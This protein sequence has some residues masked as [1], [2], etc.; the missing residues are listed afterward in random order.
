MAGTVIIATL[1][2][3]KGGTSPFPVSIPDDRRDAHVIVN[4]TDDRDNIEEW[5]RIAKMT[6]YV[7]A[8]DKTYRLGTDVTIAG[9]S[10]TDEGVSGD[11]QLRSEKGQAEG[12]CPLNVDGW[13][14]PIY[15]RK[16][17]TQDSYVVDDAQGRYALTAA[18][19]DICH[20]LDDSTV[21]VKLNNNP[22]TTTDADWAEITSA[23]EVT[24]VNGMVGEVS[25]TINELLQWSNNSAEFDTAVG[26]TSK[27]LQNTSQINNNTASIEILYTLLQ[28]LSTEANTE[29]ETYDSNKQ[30]DVGDQVI[31]DPG[32]GRY[33]YYR[34]HT[35]P[36]GVNVPPTNESYWERIGDFYTTQEID[37]MMAEKADLVDGRVPLSQLPTNELQ[38]FYV[39]ADLAERND[40]TVDVDSRAIVLN[41]TGDT[42]LPNGGLTEYLYKP[43]DP[44]AD[45]EGWVWCSEDT[46]QAFDFNRPIKRT[47]DKGKV[48]GGDTI[49]EGLENMFFAHTE[50]EIRTNDLDLAMVGSTSAA[51]I[52]GE[53]SKQEADTIDQITYLRVD[54]GQVFTKV[55][56]VD[57]SAET[58]TLNYTCP[59][60]DIG[61]GTNET[62]RVD[63]D[64][65]KD[66]QSYTIE[67]DELPFEGVYPTMVQNTADGVTDL[68]TLDKILTKEEN[69]YGGTTGTERVYFAIPDIYSALVDIQDQHSDSQF[70]SQFSSTPTIVSVSSTGLTNNW[71]TDYK[72]Y[73]S[74]YDVITNDERYGWLFNY[75]DES[76]AE[77][78]DSLNQEKL[79][80]IEWGAE[81]NQSDFQVKT[82]YEN[83]N[84]TNAFRDNDKSKLDGIEAGAQVNQDDAT[85]KTQYENNNDTNAYTDADKSKL[86]GIDTNAIGDMKQVD[87]HTYTDPT[88]RI[89]DRSLD[90]AA[91]AYN[92]TGAT[93][94]AGRYLVVT[95]VNTV[96]NLAYIRLADN[97]NN[98]RVDAW[99]EETINDGEVGKIIVLGYNNNID[100]SG[101]QIDDPA[102]L[103]QNGTVTFTKPTTGS[104]IQVGVVYSVGNPGLIAGLRHNDNLL[105]R[106]F[107]EDWRPST[108][109]RK[110][111]LA[112]VEDGSQPQLG[113]FTVRAT[114]DHISAQTFVWPNAN[115]EQVH[116][117]MKTE[118][119]DPNGVKDDAFL[120]DNFID[121]A[122]YVRMTQAERDKL[123]QTEEGTFKGYFETPN[124]LNAAY[125]TGEEGWSAVVL[126]ENDGT[127]PN[128]NLWLWQTS[129]W[130]D[131]GVAAVGGNM[132]TAVYDTQ[133]VNDDCFDMDNFREG[134]DNT[135]LFFTQTERDKLSGLEEGTNYYNKTEVDNAL[136]QKADISYVDQQDALKMD[137]SVYDTGSRQIVDNSENVVLEVINTTGA[138]LT[139]G[140]WV[141][142]IGYDA[143]S[144]KTKIGQAD[145]SLLTKADGVLMQDLNNNEEGLMRRAG[146][147]GDEN[148]NGLTVGD[149]LYLGTSGSWTA[150]KPTTGL[151]QIVGY[152]IRVDTTVGRI[153][154]QLEDQEIDTTESLIKQD[155]NVTGGTTNKLS[156]GTNLI[157]ELSDVATYTLPEISTLSSTEYG[158]DLKNISGGNTTLLTSGA[159][160]ME[161]ETEVLLL[162]GEN[163]TF[164]MK[165]TEYKII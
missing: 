163:L 34:C 56:P 89:V 59:P 125:P 122:N 82:Q 131:S 60:T 50:P 146:V 100:T 87:Y 19:G 79:D 66:G 8:D 133:N 83:N 3:G 11:Y 76:Q 58:Q 137:I 49:T 130:V 42:R 91:Q 118:T 2:R 77:E 51:T 57:P 72:L 43:S 114:Q 160:T 162:D 23:S 147:Q 35:K 124:D 26:K 86:D 102:Y 53:V 69:I 41:A 52:T 14:D 138:A 153:M 64:Y 65:T 15:V 108:F 62:Y 10:W 158:I 47:P 101:Q 17:H 36:V 54:D 136:N 113:K 94:P 28:D 13:I 24:S 45:S 9:Q 135:H 93:I 106:A 7:T 33:N 37:D 144:G 116:G 134:S 121:T 161:G 70:G 61:P 99:T 120:M 164:Y 103:G 92:S 143:T 98:D 38:Q 6:C 123:A 68:W 128:G 105:G 29:I 151:I 88:H 73:K 71:T 81:V 155:F 145:Q 115:W 110:N 117:D 67:G 90:M 31:Y 18:T 165:S 126:F 152:V 157:V 112:T 159:D 27:V 20:Q 80:S 21:W 142:V 46:D 32:V 148:T 63:V 129:A 127:T 154:V 12:Y 140:T 111:T 109:Y 39:V 44:R 22:P 95:D 75:E 40:L 85:I 5:R 97:T 74:N 78:T 84:D 139:K 132:N 1:Q 4:T 107:Q 30:Y 96:T 48:P 16:L 150:T 25:I 55:T 104:L 149:A 156:H 141:S 119:Y